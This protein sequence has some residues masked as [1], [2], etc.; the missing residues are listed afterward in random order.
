MKISFNELLRLINE[1]KAPL[2]IIYNDIV[3]KFNDKDV[4]YSN[5]NYPFSRLENNILL[6]EM[7]IKNIIILND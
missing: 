4:K 1:K 6:K 5:A 3:Y 7:I 2:R